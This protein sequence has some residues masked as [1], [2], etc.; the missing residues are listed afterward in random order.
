MSELHDKARVLLALRE[1]ASPGPWSVYG[2]ACRVAARGDY[3][4]ES[5]TNRDG[6]FFRAD[7]A[8]F[9]AAA[10]GMADTIRDLL[11]ENETFKRIADNFQRDMVA[12]RD[13]AEAHS[14]RTADPDQRSDRGVAAV[15][16]EK[17]REAL[18]RLVDLCE[19]ADM[20]PHTVSF[21]REALAQ[22][23]QRGE[24]EGMALV[25]KR[26]TRAMQRVVECEGWEWA[27]LLAAAGAVTE[28]EHAAIL[29]APP[30]P[31]VPTKCRADGR[32]Q[33]AIDSA[34]E[35]MGACPPGK[36]TMAGVPTEPDDA[37]APPVPQLVAEAARYFKSEG[38]HI[39]GLGA[40]RAGNILWDYIN[41]VLA[42]APEGKP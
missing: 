10:H 9:V 41:D 11:V 17:M 19:A 4:T 36:C 22:P 16:V 32:C 8:R 14:G 21:A 20:W 13:R 28:A 1:K 37:P 24:V 31:A 27:D 38:G 2:D 34:A 30:A 6:D 5:L 18:E 40:S 33:Y 12:E 29:N 26:M 35:G 3:M 25:P 42:A 15:N 23:E 39:G 7:D